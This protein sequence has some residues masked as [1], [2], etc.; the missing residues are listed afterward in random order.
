MDTNKIK[1]QSNNKLKP[2]DFK[3]VT[4]LHRNAIYSR[5][6]VPGLNISHHV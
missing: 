1:I 6:E 4:S 5:Y 3:I 2:F